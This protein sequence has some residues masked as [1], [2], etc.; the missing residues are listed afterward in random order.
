MGPMM[1]FR[2]KDNFPHD[3]QPSKRLDDQPARVYLCG[4][5]QQE[6][7]LLPFLSL[8][9]APLHRFFAYLVKILH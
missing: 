6:R 5:L 4:R 3:Y 1:K 9:T 2:A 7:N 8:L